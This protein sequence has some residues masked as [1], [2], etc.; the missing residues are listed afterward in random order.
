MQRGSDKHSPRKDDQLKHELEGTMRGNRS[1]RA[2]EWRDPEPP[3]EDDPI[4]HSAKRGTMTEQ[5]V[6]EV[7]T[8]EV[9][10]VSPTAPAVVA[11]R[12]MRDNDVGDVLIL[13]G[14]IVRGI[15]TDRDL[16]LRLTA[17]GMDPTTTPV[18]DIGSA[19]VVTTRPQAPAAEAVR[20]MRERALRRLPVVDGGRVVGI[21]SLGDLAVEH[22]PRSALAD[23]SAAEPNR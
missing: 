13:D 8:S 22:D 9:I 12:A 16:T 5:T 7:M 20:L 1:S 4:L 21:V 23:I 10:G 15:V 2:E 18:G 19:D 3:A 11:A 6:S 14:D 17:E